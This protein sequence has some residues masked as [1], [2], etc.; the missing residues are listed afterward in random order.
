MQ[1]KPKQVREYILVT[2]DIVRLAYWVTML[3]ILIT[4]YTAK[5]RVQHA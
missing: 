5:P 1:L 4:N 2:T 3:V